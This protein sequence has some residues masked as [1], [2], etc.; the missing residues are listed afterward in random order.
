MSRIDSSFVRSTIIVCSAIAAA[1]TAHGDCLY[2]TWTPFVSYARI[3]DFLTP[4]DFNGDGKPDVVG[5]TPAGVFIALND[6]SGALQTPVDVYTGTVIGH[7]VVDDFT[8]DGKKDIAFAGTTALIVLPGNGGGTFATPLSSSITISPTGLASARFN[9]DVSPDLAVFDAAHS[10]LLIYMNDGSG[11]FSGGSPKSLSA[12]AQAILASDIDGDSSADVVIGYGSSSTYSV[13]YGNGDGSLADAVSITGASGPRDMIAADVH[14]DGLEDLVVASGGITISVVKNLGSRTFASPQLYSSSTAGY[15]YG[16]VAGDLDGDPY[17][18]IG[19]SAACGFTLLDSSGGGTFAYETSFPEGFCYWGAPH[20]AI[21][22]AD[23]NGD[24]RIDVAS[25]GTDYYGAWHVG[26]FSNRCGDASLTLATTTPTISVGQSVTLTATI[27]AATA[28][29][30]APTGAITLH[31]GDQIAGSATASDASSHYSFAVNDLA[32]GD[33]TFTVDY[34]GDAQYEPQQATLV[35]HVTT[36]TTSTS[37]SIDPPQPAYGVPVTITAVVTSSTGDTPT[38]TVTFTI[39]GTPGAPVNVATGTTSGPRTVGSHSVNA[40][41]SGDATH[42]PNTASTT[43]TVTKQTPK[44]AMTPQSGFAGQT[45]SM[46]VGAVGID[47]GYG[48]SGGSLTVS[49]GETT[50]ALIPSYSSPFTMPAY[51]AGHYDIRVQYSGDD[52]FTAAETVVPFVVFATGG[53]GTIDARG[54]ATGVAIL[55][56]GANQA[57]QLSRRPASSPTWVS[58]CVATRD[59]DVPLDTPYLYRVQSSDGTSWSS[60]DVAM[61]LELTDDP[62]LPGTPMRVEHLQE[63][64]RGTNLL[65]AAAGLGTISR[66]VAAGDPVSAADL[67]MLRQA[68]NEARVGLGAYAYP[69]SGTI[70]TGDAVQAAHIREL[71]EAI[72]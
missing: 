68:I 38:G 37:L 4:A 49:Q 2:P 30:V 47:S 55:W 32:E 29:G 22:F 31:E 39:D 5:N 13:F 63:I 35:I 21:A 64:I 58:C 20:G 10:Q 54:D 25:C 72:R 44:L 45:T 14:N 12:N 27:Q 7:I 1:V 36:A 62:L 3:A 34:A 19:V 60:I 65:R 15:V 17:A 70:A 66:T 33:H 46:W 18:D 51:P 8:G 40:S 42:P 24:G 48:P 50:I 41:Y 57:V 28:Y 9:A 71:R 23:F 61:R 43:Y 11:A 69:F 59:T 67:T 6:G 56:Y 52:N 26:T 16:V 53:S